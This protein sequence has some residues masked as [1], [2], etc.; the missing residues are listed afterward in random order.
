MH[1]ESALEHRRLFR[2]SRQSVKFHKAWGLMLGLGL[3][4]ELWN[5]SRES[6]RPLGFRVYIPET[7]HP[8]PYFVDP[9]YVDML[10]N[11]ECFAR[12]LG[13]DWLVIAMDDELHRH[14]VFWRFRFRIVGGVLGFLNPV[15]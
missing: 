1:F 15:E 12:K 7:L 13:L 6:F 9:R 14:L 5:F 10:E 11:W 3:Q 8:K 4:L 2:D